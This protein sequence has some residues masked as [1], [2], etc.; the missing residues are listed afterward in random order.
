MDF[1]KLKHL[2]PDVTLKVVE[3]DLSG[4]AFKPE[5]DE[6]DLRIDRSKERLNRGEI[7]IP[8]LS[9]TF[10]HPFFLKGKVVE[11]HIKNLGGGFYTF[12]FRNGKIQPKSGDRRHPDKEIDRKNGGE[13]QFWIGYD[14]ENRQYYY[15]ENEE[16][17]KERYQIVMNAL[18]NEEIIALLGNFQRFITYFFS[19]T[20]KNE[21][22]LSGVSKKTV[23]DYRNV[24]AY[25]KH[26]IPMLKDYHTLLNIMNDIDDV[27]LE[28]NITFFEE[29][30]EKLAYHINHIDQQ[31]EAA[32]IFEEASRL[33]W[34][35]LKPV[36]NFYGSLETAFWKAGYYI[37]P[38]NDAIYPNFLEIHN[39]RQ[40]AKGDVFE[41]DET[42]RKKEKELYAKHMESAKKSQKV[43]FIKS[44]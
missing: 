1:S 19:A 30:E 25:L 28:H 33:H 44:E 36:S 31:L 34:D 29:W 13:T 5:F 43:Q 40:L 39:Q 7:E 14:H 10:I 18:L 37:D 22:H 38:A 16:M 23:Q 9:E 20:F 27:T 11:Y 35:E 17:F 4:N 21:H 12:V 2:K 24:F 26:A 8:V 32:W 42:L 15:I 3:R 41:S 6:E